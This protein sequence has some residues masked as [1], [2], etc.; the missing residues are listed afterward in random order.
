[1]RLLKVTSGISVRGAARW[2]LKIENLDKFERAPPD[3]KKL[4]A[5]RKSIMSVAEAD[6]SGPAGVREQLVDS[7]SFVLR[8]QFGQN[9]TKYGRIDE[10]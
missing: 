3:D 5:F 1:M 7:H 6:P 9:R 2:R 10:T 8:P 4:V